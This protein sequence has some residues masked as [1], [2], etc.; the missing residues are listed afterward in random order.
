ML[1]CVVTQLALTVA[2][3]L[4]ICKHLRVRSTSSERLFTVTE[5]MQRGGLEAE[6]GLHENCEGKR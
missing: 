2:L 6:E 1:C 5:G 3:I 4:D